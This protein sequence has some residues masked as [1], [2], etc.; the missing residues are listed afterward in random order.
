MTLAG[1]LTACSSGS[2]SEPRSPTQPVVTEAG[3]FFIAF[4]PGRRDR[5]LVVDVATGHVT[6]TVTGPGSEGYAASLTTRLAYLPVDRSHCR[7][8]VVRVSL[9][10]AVS[11]HASRR[12]AVVHGGPVD[13]VEA[14]PA[15]SLNGKKLAVVVTSPPSLDAATGSTC[16]DTD[17]VAIVSLRRGTVR[18]VTSRVGDQLDDLSWVGPRLL[19]RVTSPSRPVTSDVVAIGSETT[20]LS[21]ARTVL[22]ERRGR[23]GPVFRWDAGLAAV[24]SGRLHRVAD[25]RILAKPL[26]GIDGL[27]KSVVRVSVAAHGELLLQTRSGSVY[28]SDGKLTRQVPVTIAGRWDE[29][30]W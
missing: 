2:G 6:E 3:P 4:E 14:Q 16:G 10:S 22:T 23:P 7:L 11:R 25:D 26:A 9:P 20:N 15:L 27:P 5:L 18:Y 12:V 30:S 21:A 13:D 29:P 1:C 8:A 17:R 19:V 24:Y 28:W